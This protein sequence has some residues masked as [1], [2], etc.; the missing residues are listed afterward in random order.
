M[1]VTIDRFE[2]DYAVC[3][4]PDRTMLNIPKER[5][6]ANAKEGDIVILEDN[7]IEI[8]SGE[9][10]RRKRNIEKLMNDLWK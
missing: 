3:E 7:K 6:P 2:D 5:L 1:K 4:K 8:D 9:T 10:A